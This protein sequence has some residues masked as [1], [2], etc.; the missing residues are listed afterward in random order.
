MV[1][2]TA[3]AFLLAKLSLDVTHPL[4]FEFGFFDGFGLLIT[5]IGVFMINLFPEKK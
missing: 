5:G 2:I 4:N 1:P 3:L